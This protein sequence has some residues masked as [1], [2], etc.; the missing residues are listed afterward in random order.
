MPVLIEEVPVQF[1]PVYNELVKEAVQSSARVNYE[2]IK[3]QV[4]G[5]KYIV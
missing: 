5:L 1:I 2:S 3:K 4:I